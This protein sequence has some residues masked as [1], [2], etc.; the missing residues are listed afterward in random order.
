MTASDWALVSATLLGPMLAVQ[1]QKWIE[2][3]RDSRRQKVW[4]FQTLMS[5]RGARL[6]P[7][8]VRALNMIDVVFYGK[9]RF[10]QVRRTDTEQAVLNKWKEYLDDLAQ[11][12]DPNADNTARHDRRLDIFADML[13]AMGRDVG[14]EFDRVQISRGG[15]LPAA[16]GDEFI[17]QQAL[18]R[19]AIRV[20]GGESS[21]KMNVT[22]LPA[23]PEA[24]GSLIELYK[25]LNLA[26]DDKGALAVKIK[27]GHE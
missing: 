21:I 15:Y 10:G 24:V 7:Q 14:Y 19:L 11:E 3:W 20:F 17:E 18:R 1:A 13:L 2:R 27:S 8:H 23:N 9:L 4:V 25:R 26:L 22:S 6:S 5:T 16:H 12:W